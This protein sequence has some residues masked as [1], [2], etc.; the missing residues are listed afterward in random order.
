MRFSTTERQQFRRC[1]RAW[2]WGG[3]SQGNLEPR[4]K[5]P[6]L[7]FGSALHEAL[8]AYHLNGDN[9]VAI[10]LHSEA[11][12]KLSEDMRELGIGML[13]HYKAWNATQE[14][15]EFLVAEYPFE[16]QLP[17]TDH[18][19]SGIVDGVAKDVRGNIWLVEHKG[20]SQLASL[21]RLMLDDQVT[22]Y[23]WA[24]KETLG[25][26]LAGVLY[27]QLKK[28]LPVVPRILKN[29]G[30][31]AITQDMTY[32]SVLGS[33][34]ANGLNPDDYTDLLLGLYR[35]S[36]PFFKRDFLTRNATSLANIQERITMEASEMSNPDLP[37]YPNIGFE[38][39]RCPFFNPCLALE[40]GADPD[41]LLTRLYAKREDSPNKDGVPSQALKT[42]L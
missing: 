33:I 23:M 39:D 35:R 7:D 22:S 11:A 37:I 24:I 32:D 15:L 29:G 2:K 9:P 6:A 3:K 30:L 16:V 17:G 12:A 31:S 26:P 28:K 8:A 5:A 38:C 14:P 10:F 34:R 41:Y 19:Y 25:I 1:R 21:Q 36:N 13:E 4:G 40:D 20:Y 18:I 27:N 42:A